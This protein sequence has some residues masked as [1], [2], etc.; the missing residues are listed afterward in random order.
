[1]PAQCPLPMQQSLPN[2]YVVVSGAADGRVNYYRPYSYTPPS[3]VMPTPVT[4]ELYSKPPPHATT[5]STTTSPW[6][7]A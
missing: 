7:V 1:M 4:P 2:H 6:Y 5:S 3:T